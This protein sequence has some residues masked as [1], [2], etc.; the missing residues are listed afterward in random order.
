MIGREIAT[1]RVELVSGAGETDGKEESG[2]EPQ[3]P[4]FIVFHDGPIN[5]P[6][7]LAPRSRKLPEFR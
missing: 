3:E 6:V 1:H 4:T 2:A 5:R 7:R